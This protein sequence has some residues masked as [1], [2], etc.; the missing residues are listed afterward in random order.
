MFFIPVWVSNVILL[1]TC[2]M[3][4]L[5]HVRLKRENPITN[6][7]F[8]MMFFTMAMIWIVAVY[9]DGVW[10]SLGFFL[11]SAVCLIVMLREQRKMPPLKLFG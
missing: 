10:I 9:D 5:Q 7:Q 2:V 4:A 6:I 3:S 8:F 11:M 1:V